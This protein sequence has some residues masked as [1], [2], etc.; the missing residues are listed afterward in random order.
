M[1]V[2]GGSVS[3]SDYLCGYVVIGSLLRHVNILITAIFS[4]YHR[5]MQLDNIFTNILASLTPGSIS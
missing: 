2:Q 4:D 1:R 3:T 5:N